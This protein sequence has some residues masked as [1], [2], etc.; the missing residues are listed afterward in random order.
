LGE[1]AKRQ[2]AAS[3]GDLTSEQQAH[4][5]RISEAAR[6]LDDLRTR[7]LN[8]PEWTREEILE[9]PAIRPIFFK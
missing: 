9:F 5:A 3:T 4:H 7:W 8:P 6:A 2:D 1:G